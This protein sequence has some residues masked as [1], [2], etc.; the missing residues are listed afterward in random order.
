MAVVRADYRKVASILDMMTKG[1]KMEDLARMQGEQLG[2]LEEEIQRL[3]GE[4]G[5]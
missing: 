4:L 3:E 1:T 5:D 2:P